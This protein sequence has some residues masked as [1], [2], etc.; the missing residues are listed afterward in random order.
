VI[1]GRKSGSR[2]L[3][4]G[5][6]FFATEHA[7]PQVLVEPLRLK[8]PSPDARSL[9]RGW[10]AR[11]KLAVVQYDLPASFASGNSTDATTHQQF[12]LPFDLHGR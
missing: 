1:R 3:A 2:F 11:L 8:W 6:T 7:V 5:D 10:S 12:T 4:T 9:S